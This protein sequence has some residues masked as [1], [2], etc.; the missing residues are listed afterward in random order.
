M[1]PCV[2]N[3]VAK[4]SCTS[5]K[6]RRMND[7]IPNSDTP[8][9]D[10]NSTSFAV[11]L[12]LELVVPTFVLDANGRVLIWNNALAKLTGIS[13][14][15]VIGTTDHWRAFYRK[16]R[17]CLADLVL[18]GEFDIGDLYVEVL[19]TSHSD[20]RISAENWAHFP[21]SKES[22]YLAI[23]AGPIFSD[24]G[25]LIAVVE[26]L[27][28]ITEQK[29]AEDELVKLASVD[30]LT[31]IANRR[32]F[33]Q[34]IESHWQK[35]CGR[36][37]ALSLLLIDLDHFKHYNDRF[38]HQAGDDCLRRLA[39]LFE[40]SLPLP[41]DVVAR[42][43]GEEFAVILPEVGIEAA[44]LVA[45]RIQHAVRDL[46]IPH[47]ASPSSAHVSVSIGAATISSDTAGPACLIA[48]A[49][50]ALFRAKNDGR[51]R[52]AVAA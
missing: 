20:R 50:A 40:E 26:T 38:G 14:E 28:D 35:A 31:G 9:I 34:A 16:K 48:N 27:R 3:F 23:D 21:T 36:E 11:Q 22:R 44:E 42:Y 10:A 18:H 25:K 51:D 15:Q 1:K 8:G 47:P 7:L 41:G 17:P 4:H 37:G 2:N 43:G 33:D 5:G 24:C 32:S 19:S 30:G 39:K 45:N 12:M 6:S 49:D 46:A 52:V 13:T 29:K